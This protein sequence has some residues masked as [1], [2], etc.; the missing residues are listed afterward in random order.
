M[1]TLLVYFTTISLL[2]AQKKND[3]LTLFNGKNLTGWD[4]KMA[5]QPLNDNFKNTF[6]VKNGLLQIKY[7]QY[8]TF[9][10]KY[11][12]LFYKTPFSYFI[13]DF[14][15]RFNGEHTKGAAGFTLL[16][17]GVMFHSQ[18]AQ[19]MS[20]MQGFPISLEMQLYAGLPNVSRFT[21]NLC[22]PGT[23]VK[24]NNKEVL[25]HCTDSNSKSYKKDTWVKARLVVLGDSVVHHIIEG[26]T[27][28]TYNNTKVGKG[29]V[30][31]EMTWKTG[32]ITDQQ[33]EEWIKKDGTKLAEGYIALQ[34]ESHP[35]DFKNLKLLNLK[36]CLDPK[37][38]NYK[39]HYLISDNSTCIYKKKAN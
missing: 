21:G 19:S 25:E 30:N 7:D 39:K 4:I 38:T 23:Y 3:W 22:T 36:G 10:D 6:R 35:I 12:H 15:Y 20:F 26:D 8:E 16:N 31:E 13:F 27:V 33:A 5:G 28:L 17:S 37:A 34:A 1:K 32:G 24:I 11:A 14:E 2:F 9:N 29:F 18:S